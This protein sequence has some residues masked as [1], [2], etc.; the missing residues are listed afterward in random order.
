[1]RIVKPNGVFQFAISQR[2]LRPFGQTDASEQNTW[3]LA[4]YQFKVDNETKAIDGIDYFT[5][6]YEN[7]SI[8]LDELTVPRGK[9]VTGVRFYHHKGHV[10]LQIR[11]TDF[12]YFSGQLLNLHY[13]PWVTNTAGGAS[14]IDVSSRA[15]PLEYGEG[16]NE[17]IAAKPNQFVVFRPSDF[18]TDAAQSTVPFIET[19][20]LES[21]NPV[22]L[23]GVALALKAQMGSGGIIAPKLITYD[24]QIADKEPT[25]EFDYID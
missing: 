10:V 24:F 16:V 14:E 21:K 22:V 13:T 4:D 11:A 19:L 1:M 12:N 7:R 23:A 17:P 15:N 6:T 20:P 2:T 8:N 9:V 18:E 3:K 25:E 5:L